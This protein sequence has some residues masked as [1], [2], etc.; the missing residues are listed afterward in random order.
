MRA[1]IV[2]ASALM[3]AGCAAAPKLPDPPP[4]DTP[5]VADILAKSQPSDWRPL[6]PETTLYIDFPAIDSKSGGRVVIEMAADFAP[7]HVA[8]VKTLAREGFFKGGGVTRV[9]DNYV[10]QWGPGDD[11]RKPVKG[12]PKLK[13][14]FTRERSAAVAFTVL[15]DPDTFAPEVGFSNGF[16]AAR[17]KDRMWLAHCYGVV[18]VGRDN[19]E[20]TGSGTEL[21]AI[22]GAPPR[23]LDKNITVLGRV[24]QGMELLSALPRGTGALGFYETPDQYVRFTDIKVAADVAPSERTNLEVMRT[25]SAIFAE[26]VNSRRWRKDAFY[27]RPPGRV[28]LCNINVPARPAT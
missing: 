25:D 17:D 4:G 20:D 9:Q 15:P 27:H 18:G 7:N 1:S 12:Q 11:T 8:N 16:A 13:G 26:L 23:G 19:D 3:A 5:S 21:Y 14:E 24:V 10:T 28:G 6:D 22:N 2:V